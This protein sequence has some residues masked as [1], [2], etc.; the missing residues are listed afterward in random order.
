[1]PPVNAS[2]SHGPELTLLK[3]HTGHVPATPVLVARAVACAFEAAR[4]K[5]PSDPLY[6]RHLVLLV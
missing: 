5:L 6:L 2:T 1:V 3:G 4:L